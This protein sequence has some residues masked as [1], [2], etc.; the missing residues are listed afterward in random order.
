MT[1]KLLPTLSTLPVLE[2]HFSAGS[3]NG[4]WCRTANAHARK[5]LH[6]LR[7]LNARSKVPAADAWVCVPIRQGRLAQP[8]LR[9]FNKPGANGVEVFMHP[10]LPGGHT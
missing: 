5:K 1:N 8:V 2:L 9:D 3:A 7:M 10:H 4:V 6:A